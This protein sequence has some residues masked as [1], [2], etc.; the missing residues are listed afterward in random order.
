M[1]TWKFSGMAAVTAACHGVPG[2]HRAAWPNTA[3]C[4]MP[5]QGVIFFKNEII[6]VE[7]I[8]CIIRRSHSS[9]G[10]Y[11]PQASRQLC[12]FSLKISLCANFH[13][14]SNYFFVL[15]IGQKHF[16]FC[17][18]ADIGIVEVLT[19]ELIMG[20]TTPATPTGAE[21]SLVATA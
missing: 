21:D 7:D 20:T 12:S 8:K 3:G 19:T 6:E 15:P 16:K 14:F 4:M 10:E 5:P 11:R 18:S 17:R 13:A 9:L 2:G 1:L